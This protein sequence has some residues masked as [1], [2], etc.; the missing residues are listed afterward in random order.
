VSVTATNA[1]GS[2][3]ASSNPTAVIDQVSAPP[4]VSPPS[5]GGGGSSSGG[6]GGSFPDLSVALSAD[7]ATAPAAG[8]EV[9]YRVTVAD[10]LGFGGSFDVRLTFNLAEGYT[11]TNTYSDRGKGCAGSLSP[12]VCDLD[13]VSPL[14]DGHV[15]IWGKV[16]QLGPQVL[17]ASVTEAPGKAN[18]A[19]NNATLTLQPASQVAPTRK[20]PSAKRAP[21]DPTCRNRSPERKRRAPREAADVEHQTERTQRHDDRDRLAPALLVHPDHRDHRA[22]VDHP[23][24]NEKNGR[25]WDRTSDPSRVKRV[26]SR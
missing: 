13:W 24:Q 16:G 4:V 8:S 14:E 11:V 15:V 2:T 22:G 21:V 10:K 5:G 26:L 7:Q 1:G 3:T 17:T 19:D 20:Q 6:G 23:G 12:L 18:L 25:G 9:V